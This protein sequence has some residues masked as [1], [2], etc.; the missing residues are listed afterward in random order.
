MPCESKKISAKIIDSI[1]HDT[2][3]NKNRTL[4]FRKTITKENVDGFWENFKALER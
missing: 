2:L 4:L 3:M 1:S